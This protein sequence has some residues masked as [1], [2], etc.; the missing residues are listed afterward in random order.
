MINFS[1]Y[2]HK[3]FSPNPVGMKIM[4]LKKCN[5]GKLNNRLKTQNYQLQI[6]WTN[7]CA[8]YLKMINAFFAQPSV[9]ELKIFPN[10]L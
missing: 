6:I 7:Q 4:T 10:R 5:K 9:S 8:Y 2:L 3:G 1:C